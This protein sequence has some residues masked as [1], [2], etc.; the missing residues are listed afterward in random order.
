MLL[1]LY[2][3]TAVS[4]HRSLCPAEHLLLQNDYPGERDHAPKRHTPGKADA[5]I[6]LHL[7]AGPGVTSGGAEPERH[8]VKQVLIRRHN[9]ADT[10]LFLCEMTWKR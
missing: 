9:A 6:S 2:Q 3:R 4:S 7:Q 5:F 1:D 8:R 10:S